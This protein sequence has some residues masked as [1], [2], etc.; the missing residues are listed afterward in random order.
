VAAAILQPPVEAAAQSLS[1]HLTGEPMLDQA[2]SRAVDRNQWASL[3]I[4]LAGV[5][6]VLLFAQR[7]LVGAILSTLPAVMA[8]GVVFGVL[9]LLGKPIDLGTSLVGSMV[10]SS[11]ADFAM[12]YIWYL[13]RQP[14]SQVV[15]R[16]GPVI[17]TTA[18]V[19]GLAMGVMML[20]ASPPLRLF[21]ALAAAGML[22]SAAFTFLLVPAL[23]GKL[24]ADPTS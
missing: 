21:G 15:P 2:F 10:T 23:L 13:R 22:L 24:P 20:G 16:V 8:L 7:S 11:G 17:L 5:L 14:A 19:L 1:A 3:G 12:H 6:I 9:G 18:I 4:A